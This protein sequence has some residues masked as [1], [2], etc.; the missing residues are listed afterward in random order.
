[1]SLRLPLVTALLSA[2]LLAGA[3]VASADKWASPSGSGSTCTWVAP[4]SLS[5][6][7]AA[8][9]PA[10]TVTVLS[11]T[12]NV[13]TPLVLHTDGVLAGDTV[14]AR[15][16]IVGASNL[17][18]AVVDAKNGGTL[19]HLQIEATSSAGDALTLQNGT[20]EDL[21]VRSA[22]GDAVKVIGGA[23]GTV[24]RNT[25]AQTDV[26]G[27]YA[28][29]KLRD[30]PGGSTID[31]VGVTAMAPAADGRAIRCETSI[32]AA[33]LVN[34]LARGGSG[35]IDASAAGTACTASHSN[36][37]P[38]SSPGM[39]AGPGHQQTAPVHAD[40]AYRPAA[41]SPTIDAGTTSALMGT[42]DPDGVARTIGPKPDI[43]AYEYP[44]APAAPGE[45]A[46]A[47]DGAPAGGEQ[48]ATDTTPPPDDTATDTTPSLPPATAPEVGESVSVVPAAGAVRVRLPKGK[49]FVALADG[50]QVPVGATVDTTAG[51]VR[52]VS[53]VDADGRTQT[54]TFSGGV[55]VVRQKKVERPMTELVLRGGDFSSCRKRTRRGAARAAR[56]PRSVR[57]LWGKDNHGR[58]RTRGKHAAATVRGTEWLTEDS[59]KGTRVSVKQ[60]AVD[61]A[62]VAGGRTTR[63]RAGG[64]R[65]VRPAR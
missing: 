35:D 37:R 5:S 32:T 51:T 21:L 52:L 31:L 2:A 14:G 45:D 1:M 64:S 22:G 13:S 7:L 19:R 48:V 30:G 10:E 34:V 16:R 23:S 8:A 11:G 29:L 49:G 55:F 24:V 63:V 62:P 9:V 15:P 28:A 46:V 17:A 56:A 18:T 53:A 27:S 54:G 60:G 33:T 57:R 40:S 6:A 3:P 41:G 47:R 61:V 58:F 4:C 36:F 38:A 44:V 12:Y 50:V 39:A 59:C 26:G 42:H 20:A 43:G 25:V 65:L